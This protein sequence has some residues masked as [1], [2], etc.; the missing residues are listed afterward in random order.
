MVH[1]EIRKVLPAD[2]EFDTP[3]RVIVSVVPPAEADPPLLMILTRPFPILTADSAPE[4]D[5]PL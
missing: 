5:P 1:H 3:V 4:R 2:A